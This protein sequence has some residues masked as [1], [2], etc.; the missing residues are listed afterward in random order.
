MSDNIPQSKL[1]ESIQNNVNLKSE[2]LRA[3]DPSIYFLIGDCV[4]SKPEIT[5][6][7]RLQSLNQN[8]IVENTSRYL[9]LVYQATN[10]EK[11][12]ASKLEFYKTRLGNV[13]ISEITS[14]LSFILQIYENIDSLNSQ[15]LLNSLETEAPH[16]RALIE[17]C[18]TRKVFWR[19]VPDYTFQHLVFY[20]DWL[21]NDA[22]NTL[23]LVIEH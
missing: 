3:V 6:P 8:E 21:V 5:H 12:D 23:R 2:V 11:N 16:M 17:R 4:I 7:V 15:S 19:P 14:Y 18:R 1:Y 20:N 10:I 22:T 13:L 9:T